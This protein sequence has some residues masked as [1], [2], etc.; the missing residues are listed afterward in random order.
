MPRFYFDLQDFEDHVG[1]ALPDEASA[2]QY[3]MRLAGDVI[4]DTQLDD[5][6][7]HYWRLDVREGVSKRLISMVF[8]MVPPP[9]IDGSPRGAPRL[10]DSHADG[11]ARYG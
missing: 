11:G 3:A 2:R 1:V 10:V 9:A 6:G 5:Y 7:R 8:E 4:R